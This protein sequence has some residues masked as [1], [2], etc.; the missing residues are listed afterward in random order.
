MVDH[1]CTFSPRRPQGFFLTL[2][3]FPFRSVL[4]QRGAAS[5]GDVE[6]IE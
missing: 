4:C 1:T 2:V 3:R 5:E 6:R